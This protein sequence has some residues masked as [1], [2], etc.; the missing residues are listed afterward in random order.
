MDRILESLKLEGDRST[1]V[2][3]LVK[4]GEEIVPTLLDIFKQDSNI[5]LRRGLAFAVSRIASQ[6]QSPIVK[7]FLQLAVKDDNKSIKWFA[8]YGLGNLQLLDTLDNIIACMSLP[9]D[10]ENESFDP[11][12]ASAEDVRR[13][14]A[15]AAAKFGVT[16]LS[17]VK[18]LLMSNN[19]S[20]RE[21]V[22]LSL[23]RIAQRLEMGSS[24][25]IEIENILTDLSENDPDSRVKNAS[26]EFLDSLKNQ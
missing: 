26:K 6:V 18:S 22:S 7:D 17:S 23:A 10:A 21:A 19:A 9:N 2:S 11:N 12:D 8:C 13:C 24:E 20:T 3:E 4:K 15:E 14:A 16:A 25:R 1:A 5:K